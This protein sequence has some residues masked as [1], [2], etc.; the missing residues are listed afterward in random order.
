MATN[1]DVDVIFYFLFPV[2]FTQ[3]RKITKKAVRKICLILEMS[4]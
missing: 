4:V 2:N 3:N 1:D